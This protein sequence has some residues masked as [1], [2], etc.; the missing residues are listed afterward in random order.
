[1]GAAITVNGV[2]VVRLTA[3]PV[4]RCAGMETAL[5]VKIA[6][7]ALKIVEYVARLVVMATV[8]GLRAVFLVLTI[9]GNVYSKSEA[10]FKCSAAAF[11]LVHERE[12]QFTHLFRALPA[13][14]LPANPIY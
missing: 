10:G 14:S 12:Q 5:V 4:R 7:I 1:M 13:L 2:A 8:V 6:A 9:A 11:L 3:A